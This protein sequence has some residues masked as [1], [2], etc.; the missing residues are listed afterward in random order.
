M[1]VNEI[2]KSPLLRF[3]HGVAKILINGIINGNMM[4]LL[5]SRL[6]CVTDR[7]LRYITKKDVEWISTLLVGD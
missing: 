5:T 3:I 1:C 7:S 6:M 2:C 4:S